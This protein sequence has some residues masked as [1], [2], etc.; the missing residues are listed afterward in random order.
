MMVPYAVRKGQVRE[1]GGSL[2]ILS[3]GNGLT[4]RT[5]ANLDQILLDGEAG[6]LVV[7]QVAR[8]GPHPRFVLK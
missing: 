6:E 1:K 5:G 4:C 8:A 2:H 7:C 3:K